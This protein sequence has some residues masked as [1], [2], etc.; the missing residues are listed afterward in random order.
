MYFIS[1]KLEEHTS[2]LIKEMTIYFLAK[3]HDIELQ[4]ARKQIEM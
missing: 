3:E 4:Y 2:F 1:N